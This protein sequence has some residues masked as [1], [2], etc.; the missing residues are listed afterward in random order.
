MLA[1]IEAVLKRSIGLDATTI[2]GSAVG[3][4]VRARQAACQ[5]ADL[6]AYYARLL[7][8]PSELQDLIDAVIVPETWFFRD[9]GALDAMVRV[10]RDDMPR[11]QAVRLLSL[12][13]STGEEPYSMSMA[14]LDGG[15]V[16]DRFRIDAVDVSGRSIALAQRAI[17]GQNAFRSTDLSFRDR[18]FEQVQGGFRPSEAVRR[19]VR[20][21]QGN[22]FDPARL[23]A[24]SSQ[25]I[26]FCRNVLIYFDRKTQDAALKVL[27][28]LLSPGGLLFLGPSETSLPSRDDFVWMK[29]PMAFAFRK[30]PEALAAATQ[31]PLR[32]TPVARP[33]PLMAQPASRRL[34]PRLVESPR[35]TMP[36]PPVRRASL[37]EALSL[38][39][40]G[41]LT[42]A[43][44][45]CQAFLRENGP[46]AEAF[47]LMGLLCDAA[48][49]MP[50]AV[51]QY[52]K[53]L[54]L[55]PHHPEALA[56]LALLLEQA[57]D[58]S[59]ARV[60]RERVQRSAREGNE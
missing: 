16:P 10:I 56:H 48:G 33:F 41:N 6:N 21:A 13:C 51:T 57:G 4:A 18:H 8:S 24:E 39:D 11:T 25:E 59:G 20:F 45:H 49:S 2:G 46:S 53:A 31:P 32:P 12:P 5:V 44:Q 19:P 38:A 54:Y 27:H 28:R 36:E 15:I 40:A 50:E 47:H 7:K 3:R 22:L 26:I 60:L 9:R 42:E 1:E 55:D 29:L 14:L 17:Y 34:P 58:K 43:A 35:P 37:A 23:P 52:R 30:A